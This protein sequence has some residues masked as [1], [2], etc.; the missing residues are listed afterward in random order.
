M[1][2]GVDLYA[3]LA[4][5]F[6]E[7]L[8]KGDVGK[9]TS[10]FAKRYLNRSQKAL[11]IYRSWKAL[12]KKYQT[13]SLTSKVG[14]YPT[15]CVKLIRVYEDSDGDGLPDKFYTNDEYIIKP[16]FTKAAGLSKTITFYSAPSSTIYL[17][18]VIKLDDFEDSGSDEY[19]FF[20]GELLLKKAQCLYLEQDGRI[21][22]D[23]YKMILNSLNSDLI[24]LIQRE[25]ENV[26]MRRE[27]K[28]SE[29]RRVVVESYNLADGPG[30][31]HTGRYDR[32][33]DI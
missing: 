13:L 16:T 15:D 27:V 2:L 17:D 31:H 25:V 5:D 26:D 3:D 22:T 20:P 18:Y 7:W 30:E 4:K 6:K 33:V 9:H 28:D 32:D 10:S 19:S 14:T 8:G 11:N 1:P 23:E 21:G 29:G 12:T 24:D